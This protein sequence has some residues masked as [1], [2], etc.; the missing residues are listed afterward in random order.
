MEQHV[1]KSGAILSMAYFRESAWAPGWWGQ[2]RSFR[3][4]REFLRLVWPCLAALGTACGHAIGSSRVTRTPAGTWQFRL[5]EPRRNLSRRREAEFH[6][7]SGKSVARSPRG[8]ATLISGG[9]GVAHGE[10]NRE[11]GPLLDL[12]AVLISPRG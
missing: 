3:P 11:E 8:W 5:C 7:F 9:A 1:K 4:R 12:E 6:F 10:G 2:S